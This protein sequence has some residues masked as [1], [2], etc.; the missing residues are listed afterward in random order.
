MKFTFHKGH[1]YDRITHLFTS[2][3][4]PPL[5]RLLFVGVLLWGGELWTDHNH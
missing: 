2:F 1:S 3:L 5:M 4:R